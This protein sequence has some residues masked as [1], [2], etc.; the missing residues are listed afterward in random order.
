MKQPVHVIVTREGLTGSGWASNEDDALMI[1]IGS[2]WSEMVRDQF[3]VCGSLRTTPSISTF[4][5]DADAV[6][7][8][9][10][11]WNEEADSTDEQYTVTVNP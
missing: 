3:G 8:F 11:D 4:G 9:L 5:G 6:R 7:S 1:A 2:L 10:T